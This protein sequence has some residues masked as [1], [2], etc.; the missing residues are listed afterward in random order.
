M[1]GA[2]REQGPDF[3]L[4][5][6]H[7]PQKLYRRSSTCVRPAEDQRTALVPRGNV[8]KEPRLPKTH[9]GGSGRGPAQ[10]PASNPPE[11]PWGLPSL[12]GHA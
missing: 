9:R 1:S 2:G 5:A 10:E 3:V 12:G 4:S 7:L 6:P 8:T 11:S